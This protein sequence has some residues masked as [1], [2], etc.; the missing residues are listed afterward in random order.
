LNFQEDIGIAKK[1]STSMGT[2]ET[3][4]TSHVAPKVNG[5]HVEKEA[6]KK[7]K[8]KEALSTEPSG[9]RVAK[10]KEIKKKKSESPSKTI[11]EASVQDERTEQP[12]D[13]KIAAEFDSVNKTQ[14]NTFG[15]KGNENK[16]QENLSP[17]KVIF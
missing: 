11:P 13:P 7:R 16:P 4:A 9:V 8:K 1:T 12:Q 5:S 10:K 3:N 6:E 14:E 15:S 17:S 2:S